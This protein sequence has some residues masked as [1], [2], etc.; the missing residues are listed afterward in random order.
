MSD[1]QPT[2]AQLRAWAKD[3]DVACSP[4]GPI[5]KRVRAAYERA[6]AD[7]APD[8]DHYVESAVRVELERAS[9]VE[10]ALSASAVVLARWLDRA[11]SAAGAAAAAR[12]MRMTLMAAKSVLKPISPTR[13]EN[14]ASQGGNVTAANRLEALRKQRDKTRATRS[15]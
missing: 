5:P 7:R 8:G 2:A 14:P 15:S 10:A 11:E 4:H 3:N 6:L 1:D 9:L 12:E 13:G